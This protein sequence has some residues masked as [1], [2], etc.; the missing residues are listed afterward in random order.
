ML[1]RNKNGGQ[2]GPPLVK[3]IGMQGLPLLVKEKGEYTGKSD[4]PRS[5]TK[6][7][8]LDGDYLLDFSF[9]PPELNLP[10]HA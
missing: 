10:T 1:T 8:A 7:G 6:L 3:L 5:Y 4:T 9:I 2:C